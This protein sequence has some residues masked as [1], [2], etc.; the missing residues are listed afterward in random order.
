MN[1]RGRGGAGPSRQ[2]NITRGGGSVDDGEV[3]SLHF[4][5]SQGA[6]AQMDKDK[7]FSLITYKGIIDKYLIKAKF[8]NTPLNHHVANQIA[9]W[10]AQEIEPLQKAKD[11]GASFLVRFF[12]A[13]F[14]DGCGE[15]WTDWKF[16]CLELLRVKNSISSQLPTWKALKEKRQQ[17]FPSIPEKPSKYAEYFWRQENERLVAAKAR[18]QEAKAREAAAA[19]AREGTTEAPPEP[20][21]KY[22]KEEVL[23]HVENIVQVA[24]AS[25]K[26]I[27]L[28]NLDNPEVI[29][30]IKYNEVRIRID[31]SI[32]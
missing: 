25:L 24:R 23:Q 22:Q 13:R 8:W 12:T 18:D 16:C 30:M 31:K 7:G 17:M 6:A 4:S 32:C 9:T 2:G 11:F 3:A 21:Y 15:E 10:F 28:G 20:L 1:G 29:E 5:G 26:N 19:L 14:E 27:F